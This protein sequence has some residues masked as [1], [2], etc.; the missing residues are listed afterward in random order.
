[1]CVLELY[2]SPIMEDR[3]LDHV[4][5]LFPYSYIL[6]GFTTYYLIEAGLKLACLRLRPEFYERLKKDERIL[7]F[8][9][10]LM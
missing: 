7:P 9:G 3:H 1:M 10:L 2:S 5:R 8:F 6:L 4:S